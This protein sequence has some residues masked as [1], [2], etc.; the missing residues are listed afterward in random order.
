MSN[1]KTPD[2]EALEERLRLA[3]IASDVTELDYLISPRLMFVGPG[4]ELV[5]KDDDLQA[6]RSGSIRLRS[7][8]VLERRI[9]L[10][11]SFAVVNVVAA[12]E[13]TFGSTSFAG[14][15]RYTRV[16]SCEDGISRVVAGQV[17]AIQ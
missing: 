14:Q 6:H 9:E 1:M 11:S 4:G 10:F 7:I 17:C 13:G 2:I 3:M 12:L 16:W 5:G 8:L 15:F